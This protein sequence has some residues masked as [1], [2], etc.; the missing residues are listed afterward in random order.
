MAPKITDATQVAVTPVGSDWFDSLGDQLADALERDPD[1]RLLARGSRYRLDA[2]GV[3]DNAL[4]ISGLLVRR[5]GGPSA[6][7]YQPEGYF[8]ALNFPRREYVA[9]VGEQLWRIPSRAEC[10]MCHSREAN[11]SLTVQ[12]S[13]LNRGDQL[14]RWEAVTHDDVRRVIARV[15]A[16]TRPLTVALGPDYRR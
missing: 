3:R 10:M 1:N 5:L 12:E 2:H 4:A 13:Q 9:D 8:N 15:Y 11:F 16:A 6:R 7:P 14:A